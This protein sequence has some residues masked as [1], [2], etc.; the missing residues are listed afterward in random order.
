MLQLNGKKTRNGK[1]NNNN[2]SCKKN[3]NV[4]TGHFQTNSNVF[5]KGNS[6]RALF[7]LTGCSQSADSGHFPFWPKKHFLNKPTLLKTRLW[8]S[9]QDPKN[10][11]N[12][13]LWLFVSWIFHPWRFFTGKIS[14]KLWKSPTSSQCKRTKGEVV[15]RTTGRS[16]TVHI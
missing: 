14:L 1:K 3:E 12:A 13:L 8:N 5:N 4:T 16:S 7:L 10:C 15:V 2:K 6:L 9:Y 11:N